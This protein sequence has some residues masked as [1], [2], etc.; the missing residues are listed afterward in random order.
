VPRRVVSPARER[1]WGFVAYYSRGWATKLT[2][3][4]RQLW[5][6]AGANVPS[7]T[8]LTSG[9]LTGQEHFVGIYAVRACCGQTGLL[10]V[11]PA[12]EVLPPSAVA[13]LTIVN[14]PQGVRLLLT[15][16]GL[17]TED[18]MVFGQASCSAGRMK[19]RNVAYLGLLPPPDGGV[20]DITDLYVTRYGEPKP[21]EKVFI[22][23]RQQKNGWQGPLKE[24]SDIVPG[25]PEGQQ[26]AAEATLTL[27]PYM[28]TGCTLPVRSQ[29]TF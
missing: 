2:E 5:I 29:H 14:G 9:F 10:L 13:G 6:V 20:C 3:Q 18:I 25:N 27:N 23:T 4:Q 17:V 12:R 7:A 21:G 11:P 26:A 1:V 15:L 22:V 16:N 28:H 8:R 19:R 24:T